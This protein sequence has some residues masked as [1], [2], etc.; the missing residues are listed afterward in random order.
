MTLP[1]KGSRAITVDNVSYRWMVTGNDGVID[2][3][4]E[5]QDMKGQKLLSCFMYHNTSEGKDVP[6]KRQITPEAIKK[7]ILYALDSGW[8]P[9][10]QGKPYFG[11][12]GEQVVPILNE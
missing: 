9:N 5:Q 4:I 3:I 6:Q 2:V 8:E 1:K 12:D 7:L 11:V 10:V